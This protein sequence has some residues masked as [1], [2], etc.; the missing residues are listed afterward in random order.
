LWH[1]KIQ[2]ASVT[3]RAKL[4]KSFHALGMLFSGDRI[5]CCDEAVVIREGDQLIVIAT[6]APYGE[7]TGNPA[8][9]GVY[10]VPEYRRQ[11]L[12]CQLVSP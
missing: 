9:V 1:S 8:I 12:S 7:N 5:S 6:I 2:S 4:N 3:V 11:A 10:V